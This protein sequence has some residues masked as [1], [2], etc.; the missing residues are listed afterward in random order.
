M[1]PYNFNWISNGL[2]LTFKCLLSKYL[3]LATLLPIISGLVFNGLVICLCLVLVRS[4]TW[5][6]KKEASM[7][8][9]SFLSEQFGDLIASLI[10][11][12]QP[13]KCTGKI[14]CDTFN[15]ITNAHTNETNGILAN[16]SNICRNSIN[17]T[18]NNIITNCTDLICSDCFVPD[19]R[20]TWVSKGITIAFFN[21]L[22]LLIK[23]FF[24]CCRKIR[25]KK[26]EKNKNKN[27]DESF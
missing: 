13:Y 27:D 14:I 21:I 20:S 9:L 18:G 2:A 23:V 17:Q 15:N 10:F 26:E 22:V 16:I 19:L 1:S 7:W 5:D 11:K 12:D 3:W 4:T 25:K 24:D 6:A 8:F